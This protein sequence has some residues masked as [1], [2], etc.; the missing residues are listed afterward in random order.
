[1]K[2]YGD[3]FIKDGKFIGKFEEM[4]QQFDDP[5]NQSKEGVFNDLSRNIV[6]YYFKKYQIESS[7][8]FGCGLGNTMNYLHSQTE[9]DMLGIDISETCIKKARLR[10]PDLSF[11]VDNIRNILNYSRY[12]C[13]FFSE[14]TWCLLEDKLLDNI[15]TIMKENLTGKYFIHN[16]VFYKG[17]QKYG[18]DY[19]AN[20][21]DFIEFCPF[22]L[23]TKVEINTLS[24]DVTN[25]SCIFKI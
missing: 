10:F 23:L 5:W 9:I 7:V 24:Y 15:F 6:A 20:L 14:I 13:F 17:Q 2:K 19:F 4:Y 1:M 22:K 3:L 21:E 25:T 18:N 8:E 16:L 11:K 12:Q